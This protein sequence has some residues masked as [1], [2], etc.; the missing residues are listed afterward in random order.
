VN[1]IVAYEHG[2]DEA[3]AVI[4]NFS[5]EGVKWAFAFYSEAEAEPAK[6]INAGLRTCKESSESNQQ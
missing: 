4:H 1:E 6:T 2:K 5:E 3:G